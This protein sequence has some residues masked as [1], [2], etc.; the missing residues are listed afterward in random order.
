MTFQAL[1][2]VSA[3]RTDNRHCLPSGMVGNSHTMREDMD[4]HMHST[5]APE[6][7]SEGDGLV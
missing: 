6:R 1:A 7:Y 2:V 3:A 5:A 4:C